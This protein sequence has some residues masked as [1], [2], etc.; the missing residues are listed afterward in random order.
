LDVCVRAELGGSM[1]QWTRVALLTM[2][3]VSV[4]VHPALNGQP[5]L[6]EAPGDLGGPLADF[7]E[8]PGGPFLMGSGPP[9]DPDA[10]DNERWSSTEPMG[11]VDVPTFY[12]ARHEVTVEEFAA[13]ARQG[14]WR[15]D[16]R[17]T[18]GSPKHPVTNVSWTDALAY[19]RW[20]DKTLEASSSPSPLRKL[21]AEGWV[22]TLPTEAEWEKAARGTD[23]RIFPWGNAL[24]QDRANFASG[25]PVAVGQRAC[26][27]CAHGLS[28]MSGNVWE[29]TRSPYQPYPY[30]PADDRSTLGA[31][32][33][34]VI[35]GG[36]F[37]DPPRLVRTTA[38][39]GAEPG[40]RRPFIGFRVALVRLTK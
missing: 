22:V 8:I 23:G 36:H 11:T 35:R 7:V 16:R 1:M 30:D 28:D 21:L 37:G 32:A 13:F 9:R 33:L 3:L 10:Y 12:I 5:A 18:A 34:W 31:D 17:A 29:W 4:V 14:G 20:L 19:C 27:E 38:R 2:S 6:S 40:A 26:R 15:V 25:G 39:T 24:L